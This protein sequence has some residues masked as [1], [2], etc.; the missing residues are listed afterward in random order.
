MRQNGSRDFFVLA[1]A[2]LEGAIRSREDLIA[3]LDE[4]APGRPPRKV[5]PVEAAHA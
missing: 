4:P 3:I 5:A 1:R 2:A